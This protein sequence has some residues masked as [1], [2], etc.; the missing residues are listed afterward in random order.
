MHVVNNTTEMLISAYMVVYKVAVLLNIIGQI[1]LR[2][3]PSACPQ[4]NDDKDDEDEAHQCTH[5]G[6][7]YHPSIR[8]YLTGTLL[9][10]RIFKLIYFIWEKYL[11]NMEKDNDVLNEYSTLSRTGLIIWLFSHVNLFTNIYTITVNGKWN[12][13]FFLFFFL[14][15]AD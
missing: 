5:C 4:E 1:F 3:L 8:C 10:V 12:Y 6:S 13:F 15:F 2:I 7:C 14:A 11:T 9:L